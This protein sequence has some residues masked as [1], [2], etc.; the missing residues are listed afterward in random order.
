MKQ[1]EFLHNLGKRI[2]RFR[3]AKGLSQGDVCEATGF[4]A[5]TVSALECGKSDSKILTY[6]SYAKFL[7]VDLAKLISDAE[8]SP[9]IKSKKIDELVE[10]L[11]DK[12]DSTIDDAIKFIKLLLSVV[13]KPKS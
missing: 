9:Y 8:T 3:K 5:N 12:D 2:A 4:T 6:R 1:T 13:E 7:E 10:L 11:R